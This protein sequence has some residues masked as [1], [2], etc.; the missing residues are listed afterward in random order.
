M[1]NCL[2]EFYATLIVSDAEQEETIRFLVEAT[3][4]EEAVKSTMKDLDIE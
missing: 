4:F 2:R 1:E 3:S